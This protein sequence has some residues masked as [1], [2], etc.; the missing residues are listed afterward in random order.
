MSVTAARSGASVEATPSF[1]ARCA[2]R[3]PL[4]DLCMA[5]ALI[6]S[7]AAC[8]SSSATGAAPD[9]P[10]AREGLAERGAAIYTGAG[11]CAVCHGALGLG[12]PMGPNLT[13]DEWLHGDGSIESIRSVI[14]AGVAQPKVFSR[15]MLPKGGTSLSDEDLRAVVS[16]VWS[17]SHAR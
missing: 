12:T 10:E 9:G 17:L 14:E 2:Q 1:L 6:A 11:R 7:A 4:R 15:P 5:V 8:A 16:Y 13:D 3:G